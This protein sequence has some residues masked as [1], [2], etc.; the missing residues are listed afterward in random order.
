MSEAL[1]RIM[2]TA[3]RYITARSTEQAV[4][5]RLWRRFIRGAKGYV[6]RPKTHERAPAVGLQRGYLQ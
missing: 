3:H 2:V 5:D 1:T 4:R 6:D